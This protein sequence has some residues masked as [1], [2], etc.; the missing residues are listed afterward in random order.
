MFQS[1]N[2]VSA[3]RRTDRDDELVVRYVAALSVPVFILCNFDLQKLFSHFDVYR[4]TRHVV[5]LDT[6]DDLSQRLDEGSGF[7]GSDTGA[8]KEEF[9]RS[10]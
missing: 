5:S 7:H 10:A 3:C 6:G 4:F 9:V 8:G 1:G 2:A